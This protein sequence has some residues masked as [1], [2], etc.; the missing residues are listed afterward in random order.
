[1]TAGIPQG[2]MLGLLLWDLA[3]DVF[4]Q[5]GLPN[6][7]QLIAYADDLAITVQAGSDVEVELR[8]NQTKGRRLDGEVSA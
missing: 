4:P 1:M 2:S 3:Y 8:E 6:D 7:V 5:L